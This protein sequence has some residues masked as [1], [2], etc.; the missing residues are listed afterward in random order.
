MTSTFSLG[1]L[2]A[3]GPSVEVVGG[4][5]VGPGGTTAVSP[6]FRSPNAQFS[7]MPLPATSV[8]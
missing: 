8:V 5:G 3:G 4:V 6:A 1:P 2:G 7:S